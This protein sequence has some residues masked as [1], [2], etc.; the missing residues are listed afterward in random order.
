MSNPKDP[1]ATDASPASGHPSVKP[2]RKAAIAF[3]LITVILDVLSLGLIIPV[4]QK[5]IK[6][7]AG[8]D[9]LQAS[10]YIGLF[11]TLWALMQFFCSPIIG[12]LSDRFGRRPVLLVST[13]T[14]GLDFILL[15]LA[16]SLTWLLVGRIISGMTA[17]SF[18][19]AQAYLAD[20][21]TPEKRT[22]AF[23]MFGACFGLGF[24]LGPVVG[25]LLGEI[26]LRLPFWASAGLTLANWLYGYFVLPESLPP[27][28]RAPFRWSR[29]NPLGSLKLLLSKQGL[30]AMA[31]ILFLYQLAHLAFQNIFVLYTET[32]FAWTPKQIG[33][34]LGT[35]GI[36]NFI[37]Q[38]G[39]IRPATKRLGER[40]LVF[41]GL[42]G[43]IVGFIGYALADDGDAFFQATFIFALM[44]F[45]QASINGVMSA[46]MGAS[47]QG[48]L[49]GANSSMMGI[50]GLIGPSM[51]AT[52]FALSIQPEKL[53][54]ILTG[55]AAIFGDSAK[56][57]VQEYVATTE[58][59]N[60]IQGGP[61]MLS[62][63]ILALALILAFFV[64]PKRAGA[65]SKSDPVV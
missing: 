37:V 43:G 48:R 14:L 65:P 58:F 17:A 60:A 53:G 9:E 40:P 27:E 44:G 62:A 23:G 35:V 5:L 47:E 32:H 51:Y 31:I 12:A 41:L 49:S 25:G 20:V 55:A 61:F 16:P 63:A 46:K 52:T 10:Y 18:S 21:T 56:R 34:T 4:L 2:V 36:L 54:G 3:I 15:A 64:V 11:G 45:F 24:I 28:R 7:L 1:S 19:T 38:G 33:L 39:L 8:G 42:I 26:D 50:A 59:A 6:E 22:A 57:S 30:L 29:A 13:F